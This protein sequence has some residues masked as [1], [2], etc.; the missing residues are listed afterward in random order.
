MSF[1]FDPHQ[2]WWKETNLNIDEIKTAWISL[3]CSSESKV[4][5]WFWWRGAQFGTPDTLAEVLKVT[6]HTLLWD[7]DL[8]WYSPSSGFASIVRSTASESTA[9][10][11]SHFGRSLRFSQL[12]R[13]F[14]SHQVLRFQFSYKYF[15]LFVCFFIWVLWHINL[16]RLFNAKLF[17]FIQMNS[18]IWNNS[19]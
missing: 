14:S 2:C 6:N 13:N 11:L 7:A 8:T 10:G 1:S 3:S 4:F 17:I 15:W 5:Q 12:K 16:C 18:S 19:V 9:F